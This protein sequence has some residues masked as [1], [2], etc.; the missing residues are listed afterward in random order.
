MIR[1]TLRGAALPRSACTLAVT[2][3]ARNIVVRLS[4]SATSG[5]IIRMSETSPIK[6][7]L[8]E[9]CRMAKQPMHEVRFGSI[10]VTDWSARR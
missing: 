3:S 10:E 2:R 9:E 5:R 4:T 1:S 6:R 7:E 8:S